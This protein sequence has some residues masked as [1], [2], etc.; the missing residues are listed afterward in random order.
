MQNVDLDQLDAFSEV[1]LGA[2]SNSA[3]ACCCH[4][5]VEDLFED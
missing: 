2:G 5:L 3:H 1:P 4:A